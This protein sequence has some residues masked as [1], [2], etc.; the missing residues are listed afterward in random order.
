MLILFAMVFMRMTGAIGLSDILGHSSFTN[1]L[2]EA[3]LMVM[4]F[5]L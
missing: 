1:H 4:S 2:T 5:L 3:I